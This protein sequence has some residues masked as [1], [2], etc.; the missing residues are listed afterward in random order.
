MSEFPHQ[1]LLAQDKQVLEQQKNSLYLYN[2]I[3]KDPA[4]Q[5]WQFIQQATI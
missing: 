2:S 5:A 1:L 4:N 3:M